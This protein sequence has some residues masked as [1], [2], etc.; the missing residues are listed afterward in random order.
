MSMVPL[1]ARPAMTEATMKMT[2]PSRYIRRRPRWSP[3]RPSVTSSA[4]K[5]SA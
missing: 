1:V 3:S 2:S 5:T 4:A